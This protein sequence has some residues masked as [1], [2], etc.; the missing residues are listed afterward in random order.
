[1][2]EG[3]QLQDADSLWELGKGKMM[4][5]WSLQRHAALLTAC[6]THVRLP[7]SRTA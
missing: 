1:M 3:H 6:E 7:T 4:E 2:E 5:S